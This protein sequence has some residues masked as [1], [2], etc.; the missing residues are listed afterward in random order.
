MAF[1][2]NSKVC[3]KT[4]KNIQKK[5]RNH[6]N[7]SHMIPEADMMLELSENLK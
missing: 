7:Q 4:R 3:Q 1:N 2:K 5:E 6:K